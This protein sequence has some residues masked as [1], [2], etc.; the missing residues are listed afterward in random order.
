MKNTTQL[1]VVK[2]KKGKKTAEASTGNLDVDLGQL[3]LFIY[4]RDPQSL[5]PWPITGP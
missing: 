5:E 1:Q 4:I 2:E 3:Y